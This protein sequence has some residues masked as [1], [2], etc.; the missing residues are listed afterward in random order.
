[1]GSRRD[2]YLTSGMLGSLFGF[3]RERKVTALAVGPGLSQHP[4]TAMA[5]RKIVRGISQNI[6][7]DADGL[8]AYRGRARELRKTRGP[9]ILTPHSG[10]L[11]RLLG[12]S[13]E[14]IE[15]NRSQAARRLARLRGCV[16]VLKGHRTVI[17]DG[18]SIFLNTTGN[19][20]M[21]T[22]GSGDVLCG[23]IGGF[24]AQGAAPLEAA[25]LGVFVHGR[26][27]DLAEKEVGPVG[28]LASEISSRIP[29][30]LGG[31]A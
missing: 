10:E 5:V 22:A 3:V 14:A 27:G 29:R 26:A 8:N 7:L 13:R 2:G 21:A 19:P 12:T 28:F 9:L 15:R 23:V 16:V 4:E 31:I 24:L 6:V 30:A 1:M 25:R 11:S 20:G 18:E 17:T